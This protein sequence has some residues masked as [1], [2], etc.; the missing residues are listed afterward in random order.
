VDVTGGWRKL[1]NEG[2]YNVY[3][4]PVINRATKSGALNGQHTHGRKEM[5][6]RFLTEKD[7]GKG[8]KISSRWILIKN[9]RFCIAFIWLRIGS[10]G[11]IL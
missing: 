3:S 1:R 6:S 2:H 9:V 11:G 5:R 8:G 7:T 4:S 10:S